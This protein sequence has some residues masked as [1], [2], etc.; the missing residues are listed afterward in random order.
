MAQSE[1]VSQDIKINAHI[2][3]SLLQPRTP[4]DDLAIIIPG[5]GPTDRNG[6]QQFTRND[7]LLKLAQELAKK[8]IATFRY[9]KK[10]LTLLEQDALE[11]DKLRF[12]EFVD[13]AISSVRFFKERSSYRNIYFIGHSQGALVGMLAA[14]KVPVQGYISLAG[15]GQSIDQTIINQIRLQMPALTENAQDAFATLKEN[16]RVKDYSPALE[17]ILSPSVQAFMASWMQYDPKDEIKKLTIPILLIGGSKDIQSSEAEF[18]QL[19]DAKPDATSAFITDMNHVLRKIEGNDLENT[20]SYNE[21]FRPIMN[22]VVTE[23]STFIKAR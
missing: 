5:S 15:A 7:A 22:E 14:Q 11:E 1:P 3:G 12:D 19:Q 13:D 21:P 8:N 2:H 6:N 9:D 4:T 17:S 16:G 18:R 20:K 23:I 10:V